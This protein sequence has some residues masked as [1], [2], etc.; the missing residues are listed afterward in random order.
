MASTLH[1]NKN[2]MTK[3]KNIDD[4]IKAQK[5]KD[6]HNLLAISISDLIKRTEKIERTIAKMA[7]IATEYTKKVYN[8]SSEY[9][10]ATQK[11]ALKRSDGCIALWHETS[12]HMTRLKNKSA[13]TAINVRVDA[14]VYLDTTKKISNVTL[15]IKKAIHQGKVALREL[16]DFDEYHQPDIKYLERHTKILEQKYTEM[17]IEMNQFTHTLNRI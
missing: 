5:I 6:S 10:A 4:K 3:S 15:A 2:K 8:N 16:I 14:V 11:D 9:S 1:L 17:K 13:S 7:V 12:Q